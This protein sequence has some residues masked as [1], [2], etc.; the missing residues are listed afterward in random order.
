M[1]SRSENEQITPQ[2]AARTSSIFDG[3]GF[4][5]SAFGLLLRANLPI[6]GLTP[7]ETPVSLP[8]IEIHLGVEPPAG[9]KAKSTTEELVYVSSYKTESGEPVFRIWRSADEA[10][11]RLDYFDGVRFWLDRSFRAIWAVWPENLLIDDA[12]AYLL[13]PVIG[14]LLRLRGVICLHASAV[15]MG[16]SAFVFVGSEGAGKSTTAAA[17]AQRGHTVISDDIVA[18]S[19]RDGVFLAFPACPYLSLWPESVNILYGPEKTLPSFSPH[20][21]KRQLFLT[22]NRLR[23]A[24]EP[25]P[26]GAIFLLGERS[27]DT[28]AP[29]VENLSPREKLVSLVAN[30]YATRLLDLDKELRAREFEFLGRLLSAIP[31]WRLQPHEDG[32]RIDR[33]CDLIEGR[34]ADLAHCA[35]RA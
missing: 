1:G 34:R 25:Q 3:R 8:D 33:L 22:K 5:Y 7:I 30:S 18:L 24:A 20:L 29:F 26:L 13:G 23:F 14:L 19:E 27:A 16:N 28:A 4:S 11:L 2:A 21:D 31:V 32:S 6:P 17:L 15:A 9:P 12:V 35:S 10:F